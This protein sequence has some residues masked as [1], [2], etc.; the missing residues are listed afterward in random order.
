MKKKLSK[1]IYLVIPMILACPVS[2]QHMNS[3]DVPCQEIG[4]EGKV[5][6]SRAF[7]TSDG[8]LNETYQTIMAVLNQRGR[9]YLRKA[10]RAWITD[11]DAICEAEAATYYGLSGYGP[12]RLACMEAA[13]RQRVIFLRDAFWWQVEKANEPE[14]YRVVL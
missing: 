6:L 5:C 12:A 9:D 14:G 11:R 13:T 7:E 1:A 3:P 4:I 2:A 10:Q 8:R